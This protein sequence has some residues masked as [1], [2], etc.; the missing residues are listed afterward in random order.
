[1]PRSGIGL[2]ELLGQS[3]VREQ[4]IQVSGLDLCTG[5]ESQGG[6]RA[7]QRPRR[8]LGYAEATAR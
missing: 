5:S 1:M 4:A 8:N 2:N 6:E 7:L 3:A